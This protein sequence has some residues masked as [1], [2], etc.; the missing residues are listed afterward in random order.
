MLYVLH[1]NADYR[2]YHEMMLPLVE[3]SHD[4]AGS[5]AEERSSGVVVESQGSSEDDRAVTDEG[6]NT[7]ILL[8]R[9]DRARSHFKIGRG[10]R[11]L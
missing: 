9:I 2:I 1:M 7:S 6:R 5:G 4:P 11:K 3:A 10:S 8:D